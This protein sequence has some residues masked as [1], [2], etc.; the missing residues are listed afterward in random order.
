MAVTL[1]WI[2]DNFDAN[3][4]R[5]IDYD[6]FK[7]AVRAYATGKI[8]YEEYIAVKAAYDDKTLLPAY[9]G[10]P[11]PTD[12]VTLIWI[13]DHYDANKNRFIDASEN[14]QAIYDF[15]VGKITRD[16]MAAVVAAHTDRTHL[17]AYDGEPPAGIDPVTTPDTRSLEEGTYNIVVTKSGYATVYAKIRITSTGNASCISVTGG[18][19]YGT[20]YPRVIASGKSVKVYMAGGAPSPGY[21]AWLASKGGLSNIKLPDIFEL[22]DEFI[23]LTTKLGFKPTLPQIMECKDAFIGLT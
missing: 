13:R 6:E 10:A 5:Y 7:V 3:K 20:G 4:D 22:K 21:D 18:L 15:N 12:G 2:R 9:D 23:G 8:T 1:T 19:C 11:P 17:P 16:Q 14:K